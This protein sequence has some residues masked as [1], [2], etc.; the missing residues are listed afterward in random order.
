[1]VKEAHYSLGCLYIEGA[2]V[3]KDMTKAFQHY[4]AAAMCG[5]VSARY[6][7]G[8]MESKARLRPCAAAL[9]DISHVRARV[10]AERRQNIVHERSRE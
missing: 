9:D 7:L 8:C 5:Q 1:M 10:F 6:N 2:D 3:E 4:E